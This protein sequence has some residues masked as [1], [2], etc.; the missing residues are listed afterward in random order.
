MS[1]FLTIQ[2]PY[3][4]DRPSVSSFAASIKPNVF[5]G[6][7]YKR[8]RERLT[9][10]TAMN[11]MHVVAGKPEGSKSEDPSAFDRAESFFRGAIISV[12]TK[13]LIDAYLSLPTGKEMW[14]TL[15]AQFGVSNAGS[16]LY[17]ME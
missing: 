11:V 7:N 12:L 9:W 16:E 4:V 8:W 13:N 10:L 1:S 2:K 14:E 3:I 15:E 5:D 17:L 6:S